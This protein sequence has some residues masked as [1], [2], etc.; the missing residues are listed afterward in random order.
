MEV[1][2]AVDVSP[3]FPASGSPVSLLPRSKLNAIFFLSVQTH[4]MSIHLQ[5]QRYK[6]EHIK[7]KVES[8]M[9]PGCRVAAVT[10]YQNAGSYSP[11]CHGCISTVVPSNL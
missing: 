1:E 8:I 4:Y 6:E 7:V 2:T 3:F 9:Q 11:G 10:A 5:V